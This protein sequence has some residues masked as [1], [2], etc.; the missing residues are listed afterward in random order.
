[1]VTTRAKA[2]YT[3]TEIMIVVAII[4]AVSALSSG[5]LLQAN[6][7]FIVSKARADLQKEARGDKGVPIVMMSGFTP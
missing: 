4:G 2:G 7:Y 3:L 6:R 1:M 5:L